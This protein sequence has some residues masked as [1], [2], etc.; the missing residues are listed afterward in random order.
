M[1][2]LNLPKYLSIILFIYLLLE[3]RYI[4]KA[5]DQLNISGINIGVHEKGP[6]LGVFSNQNSKEQLEMG[7]SHIDM[8]LGKY[9]A[10]FSEKIK[11]NLSFTGL[12]LLYRRFFKSSS[13]NTGPFLDLGMEVNRISAYSN[14]NLS[15]MTYKIGNISIRCP[16]CGTLDLSIKPNSLEVIPSL[17]MGWQYKITPRTNLKTSIGLQY[18]K[19][20]N[21]SWNYN[22]STPLP[23]FVREEIDQAI[24]KINSD[25]KKLSPFYPSLFISISYQLPK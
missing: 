25:L 16:S 9:D 11:A 22:G 24:S 1:I 21:A 10:G 17:S 2:K 20:E 4:V 8:P 12:K 7:I 15:E 5:D 13:E 6:Y 18:K 3:S 14:I 19:I 23:F